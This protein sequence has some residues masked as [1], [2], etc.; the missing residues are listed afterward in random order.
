MRRRLP[1]QVPAPGRSGR[2][3]QLRRTEF[4]RRADD[5]EET[6]RK[7]LAAYHE[8]TAPILPYYE[9]KGCLKSV[10]GMAGSID[11][12]TREIEGRCLGPWTG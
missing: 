10:D 3:R 4:T 5:N 7:R 12:V 2:L 1:R 8:Q 9:E 6:V 11:E